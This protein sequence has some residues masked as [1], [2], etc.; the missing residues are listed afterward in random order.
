MSLKRYVRLQLEV[1]L[2][3][4]KKQQTTDAMY[5]KC[6]WVTLGTVSKTAV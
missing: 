6:K 1:K 4:D 3:G 5:A 2:L